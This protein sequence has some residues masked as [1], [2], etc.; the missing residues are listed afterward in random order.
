ME[1]NQQ[2]L[3]NTKLWDK[4]SIKYPEYNRATVIANTYEN[5]KWLHV[6]PGNI[7]RAFIAS[8]QQNLLNKKLVDYGIIAVAPNNSELVDK[9]YRPHDNLSLSVIMNPDQSIK[10]EIIGSITESLSCITNKTNDWN[11]IENIFISPSLEIVSL[12]IT[13]KAYNLF[14]DK[15]ILLSSVKKELSFGLDK[16][17]YTIFMIK[18]VYL[19]YQ[20]F[21][22]TNKELTLLSL[23]N[24][25]QN[26]LVLKNSI[27]TIA[28]Y[29]AEN[30]IVSLAFI[31]YLT[32]K[33]TYPC[34]MIDKIT[35][36]P[37]K[38]ILSILEQD[39][40]SDMDFVKSSRGSQYAPFTN[41]E[42]NQYLVIEDNFANGR[43]P[44]EKAGVIFTTKEIVDKV[45]KMK[46][47]TCLNPLHTALAIFGC[48]LGYTKISDEMND[49]ILKLLIEKISTE[50]MLVVADP[51][52]LSPQIFLNECINERFPN[53]AI[54]DTP[55]RIACDTSQKLGIRFGETIKEY[56]KHDTLDPKNLKY[57]PLVIAGWCRYLIGIDDNGNNFEISPDPLKNSL[58]SYLK[59]IKIAK[60]DI[61]IRDSLYP[62]LSN[63]QI[64]GINLYDIDLA[65]KIEFYFMEMCTSIHA[66]KHTLEKYLK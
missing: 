38:D 34:S 36:H 23:D 26:G 9:I 25:S 46:V 37:S 48:L 65:Q 53:P 57:I 12:T 1:L 30:K 56:V 47:C 54:P 62:I 35:P 41:A 33:I 39:G 61:S 20:R 59:N 55:Q 52:V 3:N 19:L 60:T 5:P 14:D 31:N 28:K 42:K 15:S 7:F 17:K 49:P 44:L 45:E 24:C 64:F 13:E 16:E 43:P 21:I 58:Q 51:G 8:L 50:S 2:S 22:S 66:V 40:F 29:W 63:E 32:D 18:L 27:L 11:R 6:G 4:L 10:K